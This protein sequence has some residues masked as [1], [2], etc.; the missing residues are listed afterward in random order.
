MTMKNTAEQ[1]NT[2]VKS[3]KRIVPHAPK[4]S[5]VALLFL[6]LIFAMNATSREI[7]NRVM[8][9]IVNEYHLSADV[10][11]TIVS[12]IMVATGAFSILG[13]AWSDK[14]GQ[15]WAR[16]Y[17]GIWMAL[18]YTLF[19]ILTGVSVLTSAATGFV[20]LQVIKNAFGGVGESIEVTTVS[21]W[22]PKERRGF[23]LGAHHSAYP[24]GTLFSGLL[25]SLILLLS[26]GNWRMPFLIIPLLI[27]PIYIGYW[28]FSSSKNFKRYEQD[29]KKMNLTPSLESGHVHGSNK[30][31]ILES[32]KNPNILVGTLCVLL[33]EAAFTGLNFWLAPYLAFVGHFSYAAAAGWSVV[34]TITGGIGQIFWGSISDV[35]GRK[36]TMLIAFA[37]LTIA[38]VLFQFSAYSIFLL[39]AI[40]LFA[41]CCTNAIFPVI[42]SL[43]TDS[44]KKGYTGTAMGIAETGMYIGGASPLVLGFFI[45]AGG[46]WNAQGGYISGLYFLAFCMIAAFILTIFFT[47]E[48]VGKRRGK[49]WALVGKKSC[50]I[51]K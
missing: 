30:G 48:T 50:G 32:L 39:V 41:G 46:G 43:V 22:W 33:A 10:V 45:N 7:M 18:G 27:I 36:R 26:H 15:G 42:F 28:V 21:E 49:D 2:P 3:K 20:I 31:A 13:A 25:I 34:F 14:K 29:T 4:L 47:R 5:W 38:L 37:W 8:P 51:D 40:Q 35:I 12:V 1:I 23:A 6:W 9:A 19:S 17:S 24:W 44:A 11:G 16:K